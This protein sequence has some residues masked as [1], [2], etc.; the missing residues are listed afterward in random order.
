[1]PV[2]EERGYEMGKNAIEDKVAVTIV[3][4]PDDAEFACG[5]TVAKWAR[6]GWRVVYI[7]CTD[8]S[9]GGPEAGSLS[10]EARAQVR[11]Q[12]V[13]TREEEQRRAGDLLGVAEVIFLGHPD[14]QL[15][16][17][18]EI[19]RQLVRLLRIYRPQRVIIPSPTF[20]WKHP[21]WVAHPDHLATGEAALRAIYPA[22]QNPWAFPSLENEGLHPHKV[23]EIYVMF[24]PESNHAVDISET[25]AA[26]EAAL[27][28][29]K[30]QFGEE[31]TEMIALMHEWDGTCGKRHGVRFAEEYFVIQNTLA[32]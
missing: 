27:R 29:H 10:R 26:K 14:G 18:E 32:G 3:A 25:F 16:V 28:A 12:V 9:G 21:L 7:I 4:H 1:M 6:E 22:A 2:N 5:G 24:A 20:S 13:K 11:Q 15:Q 19:Q 17:T 31:A 30:S 23:S 8:G